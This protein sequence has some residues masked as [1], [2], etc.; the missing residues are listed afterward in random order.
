MFQSVEY[1]SPV[2]TPRLEVPSSEFS[3][4]GRLFELQKQRFS[5]EPPPTARAR[6]EKLGRLRG[7][8]EASRGEIL[9]AIHADFRKSPAESL[10]TEIFVVNTELSTAR[11]SLKK[12]IK[13]RRIP[14]RLSYFGARGEIRVEPKGV[15]LILSP[16]NF[17]FQLAVGP[18][19]SAIAAGNRAIVKPSEFSPHTSALLKN[20]LAG[21]FPQ[22]E[23]AVVEGDA[24]AAQAL[25]EFPFDHI[26]FTG[27][28][29]VGKIVLSAAAKHL[30]PV[31]LELGGKCPAI[32]DETA[33]LK[34]ASRKIAWGKFLNAGQT[35]VAPD[36][37]VVPASRL[38]DFVEEMKRAIAA[39]YGPAEKIAANPDY[40]RLVDARHFG[41]VR[42]LLEDAVSAGA[43]IVAGG[44]SDAGENFLAPTLVT[45][46]ARDS[47]LFR[48]EIFGPVLPIVG[49]EGMAEA[50]EIVNSLPPPLAIYLFSRDRAFLDAALSRIPSGGV[51][52]ND[53]VIHFCHPDLPFGGVRE[54]GF[55]RSHGEAGFREFSRE[56]SIL[57]QPKWT[58]MGPLYPP[59]TPTR[60]KL[61]GL[62][63]RFLAGR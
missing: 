35:C 19:V 43:R 32:L 49:F 5:S 24:R 21:V 55:G 45:G 60:K 20:F 14:A 37:I 16:W 17:P 62:A 58:A 9:E 29:A 25:L 48:K 23:V 28:T 53:V 13:P 63:S 22:D 31:T 10:L 40:C 50:I 46:V 36:Y 57:R 41:A 15:V 11:R 2:S 6:L 3:A 52:V 42:K 7:A 44:Q 33:D 1:A 47:P 18:L 51:V 30:T 8:I 34:E 4:I 12:W 27:S 54:S 38:E 56:R 59:Y 61:L 26:F 39:L